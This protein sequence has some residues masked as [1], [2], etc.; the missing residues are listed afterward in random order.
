MAKWSTPDPAEV[1]K[2]DAWVSAIRG[3][4]RIH[5]CAHTLQISHALKVARTGNIKMATQFA[6]EAG[7]PAEELKSVETLIFN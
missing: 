7:I 6:V 2:A 4:A 1:A 3:L 5:R